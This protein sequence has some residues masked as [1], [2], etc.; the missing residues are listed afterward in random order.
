MKA[1]VL[2]ALVAFQVP[3]PAPAPT[4]APQEKPKEKP[5]EKPVYD[6]QADG[7]AQIAAALARAK[8]D[9][10]RVLVQWGANWCGWCKKLD[11]TCKSDK[12]LSHELLYE[13]EL[14]KI[15]VGHFDKHM[16]LVK[17]YGA[18]L[19]KSGIPYLT[20]LDGDGK[21]VA[22][23]ETGAL[24]VPN[25]P[26]H[27]VAKV[28]GFLKQHEAAKP[29]AQKEW[30]AAFARAKSEGKRVWLH[31]GAP[32]CGWC[33]RLEDWMA[34]P[35]IAALLAKDFVDLKID[36]DRAVGAKA[37][38]ERF[39]KSSDQGIPWFAFL[40]A[41]GKTLA[42]SNGAKGRNVGFPASEDELAHFA[43][44]LGA[45]RVHLTQDDVAALL[46]SLAPKKKE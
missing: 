22:N 30:D 26:R 32:W 39:P 8:R 20:V 18:E 44:M 42:D 36:V 1:L 19:E 23:Q 4:P 41:D 12:D 2:L 6:E 25:E 29:D 13:Y 21:V 45:A 34:R 43:T 46:A 5:A 35:E 3:A 33:H 10:K 17:Q 16:A 38:Q 27:D 7:A 28:L 11:A 37:I 40:D 15:D 31:F 9:S 14:V 24:E